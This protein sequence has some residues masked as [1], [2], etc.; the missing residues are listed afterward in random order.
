MKAELTQGVI[1]VTHSKASVRENYDRL[2]GWYDLMAGWLER[3]FTR[4]GLQML[5]I[6]EDD[7]VLEIGFGTGHGILSM[8]E[9]VGPYGKVDGVDLSPGMVS[10]ARKRIMDA[11]ISERVNLQTGD[12]ITVPLQSD[13]YDAVFMSFVLELFDTP[14]I[15]EV[16]QRSYDSL[17]AG[18]RICVVALSKGEG[19]RAVQLYELGHRRFPT[20]LDCR[21]IYPVHAVEQA[22]FEVVDTIV[23][24]M[25][26]L[27]V[28]IVL[29]NK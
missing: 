2:S 26:G 25:L 19:G 17:R 21:P 24:R 11:G 6:W 8:A 13:Y 16:L 4:V 18:G 15:P 3:R 20:L 5:D 1:R 23:M 14:E 22:G 29:A 27:P 12:A 28:E 10:V 7:R 9:S